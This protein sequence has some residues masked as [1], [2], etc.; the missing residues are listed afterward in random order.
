MG[1]TV[2]SRHREP[3]PQGR[4]RC[5][6]RVQFRVLPS[7]SAKQAYL[8]DSLPAWPLSHQR[9]PLCVSLPVSLRLTTPG[10]PP[11]S[12]AGGRAPRPRF[13]VQ[14]WLGT[15]AQESRPG[16][17]HRA[18][19]A[20]FSPV[21]LWP[22]VTASAPA[23]LPSGLGP[24]LDTRA[25]R[26]LKP[27]LLV[28]TLQASSSRSRALCTLYT[29]YIRMVQDYNKPKTYFVPGGERVSQV[30]L[31]VRIFFNVDAIGGGPARLH[32]RR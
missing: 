11:E 30:L 7:A 8:V 20:T 23:F 2:L 16:S 12:R 24:A 3:T 5:R 10:M 26:S 1:L 9:V 22:L 27:L 13:I 14:P 19:V 17:C 31:Q 15:C 32:L 25:T 18:P 29:Y 28:L 21:F 4:L 6:C